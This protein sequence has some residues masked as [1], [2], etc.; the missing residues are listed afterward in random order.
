VSKVVLLEDH[1]FGHQFTHVFGKC[2]HYFTVGEMAAAGGSGWDYAFIDFEL[3]DKY[4]GLGALIYFR[5][6]S[7]QTKVIVFTAIGER[8]RTLFALAARCWFD[9]WALLDKGL[10]SDETLG[11]VKDGVNPTTDVWTAKLA[12]NGWMI[13]MLFQKPLWLQ[14]WRLWPIYDGSV[15]ALRR[16]NPDLRPSAIRDFSEQA[17]DVV[18][19]FQDQFFPTEVALASRQ[20]TA[21]AVPLSTFG[22]THSN[23]FS[24]PELTEVLE[25]AEPWNRRFTR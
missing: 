9:A 24:A 22:R 1:Q 4:T 13:N 17:P 20:N 15:R 11:M 18:S 5:E 2:D 10:A 6:Y 14:M 21:R 7:P 12:R 19:A 16:A 25:I 23:F 3:A 8:G